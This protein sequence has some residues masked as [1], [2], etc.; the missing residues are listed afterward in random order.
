MIQTINRL[1]H[2]VIKGQI[3]CHSLAL[4]SSQSSIQTIFETEE[5]LLYCQME[6]PPLLRVRA[7]KQKASLAKSG[8]TSLATA[9]GGMY[10][11]S[12]RKC[13]CAPVC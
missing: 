7:A 5:H 11:V 3:L 12:T 2:E 1:S 8:L 9:A 4:T 10:C 6:P 13:V